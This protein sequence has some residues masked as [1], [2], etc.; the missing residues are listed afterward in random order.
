M[1]IS[2]VFCFL[3]VLGTLSTAQAALIYQAD[4]RFVDH[5]L[6]EKITP[7]EPFAYFSDDWWGWEAGAFQTSSMGDYSI[8]GEG[9]T[10]AGQDAYDHYG[11]QGTSAF[12]I[13]FGVDTTTDFSLTGNVDAQWTEVYVR[14]LEDSKLVFDSL[15]MLDEAGN[16]AHSG[17]LSAGKTYQL[18]AYS[19]ADFSDYYEEKWQF[20]L[21]AVPLPSAIWLLGSGLLG[22]LGMRK[23]NC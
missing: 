12:S 5:T 17:L 21:T 20:S 4:E 11:A 19:S 23:L 3:Y 18:L 13:T 22:L 6:G 2:S 7:S 1:R 8:T 10:Y 16:F 15:D 9:W 14:L